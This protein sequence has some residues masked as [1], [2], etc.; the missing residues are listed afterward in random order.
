MYT[1]DGVVWIHA[2]EEE[3]Q[4]VLEKAL[5]GRRIVSARIEQDEPSEQND[6]MPDSNGV[7]VLD[8]GVELRFEASPAG[9]SC[10]GGYY[11]IDSI[12]TVDNVITSVEAV[13]PPEDAKE[14]SEVTYNI[15]VI[16]ACERVNVLEV[17]GGKESHYNLGYSVE[18][19]IG[20]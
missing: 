12:A 19:F 7:M 17:T 10:G 20:E 9:C 15:F 11:T 16:A 6:Q 14:Y 13:K 18:I 1:L 8:N 4:E 3:F 2:E 5:I